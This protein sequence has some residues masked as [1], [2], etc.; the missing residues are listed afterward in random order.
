MKL[1]PHWCLTDKNP[2]FFDMDSKTAIEQTARIYAA[3]Q[4]LIAEYNKFVDGVNLQIEEFINDT[5]KDY[6]VFR[7]G[8]RQEFQDFIDIVDLKLMSQDKE[9]ENAINYM[10]TNLNSTVAALINEMRENGELTNDIM[11]AFE[12]LESFILNFHLEFSYN[13]K[14]ES[15]SV[16]AVNGSAIKKTVNET[17]N[18]DTESLTLTIE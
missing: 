9:L 10:Q 6:E 12:E 11:A 13:E 8:L 1:L 15:L 5:N 17:Y 14:D 18:S 2:A 4:E 3:M 7:T 16:M